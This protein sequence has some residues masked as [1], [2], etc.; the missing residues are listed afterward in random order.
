MTGFTFWPDNFA[1]HKRGYIA[2]RS[3]PTGRR[4]TFADQKGM[5]YSVF[6]PQ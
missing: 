6:T 2:E 4:Q 5:G 3:G 1:D